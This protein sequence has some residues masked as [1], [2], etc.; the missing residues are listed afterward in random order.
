MERYGVDEIQFADDNLT[1][2]RGRALEL[3]RRLVEVGLPWCT[4]NGTM[5]NTL[6]PEMIDLMVDSGMYQITLSLDSANVRTLRERHRKPVDLDRVPALMRQLDD[7]GILIHG[8]LVVGMPGET[9]EEI[10]ESFAFVRALPF[11]SLG[12]FIAQAIPG[13][14][15]YESSLHAGRITPLGARIIDTSRSLLQ[16]SSIRPEELESCVE[17]FLHSFNEEVRRRNPRQWYQKY[18]RHLARLEQICI[19]KAAPN[20]DG[21][22]R[23]ANAGGGPGR[24]AAEP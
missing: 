1:F 21:I 5:V 4:P 17:S 8:T 7:R 24:I 9:L 10:E 14:E 3:F 12:V 20:M 11:H 2:H 15:L 18:G 19:G 6:T 22:I 23:A 13:S 16:L